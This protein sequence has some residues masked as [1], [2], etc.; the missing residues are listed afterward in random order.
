LS[1]SLGLFHA[2]RSRPELAAAALFLTFTGMDVFERKVSLRLT[3]PPSEEF[4]HDGDPSDSATIAEMITKIF[5]ESGDAARVF[6][7]NYID[8]ADTAQ[9][10]ELLEQV[11]AAACERR[12][13]EV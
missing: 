2:I 11:E 6:T 3:K 8:A 13:P 1:E 10:S 4:P 5:M 12:P 7:I 9:V